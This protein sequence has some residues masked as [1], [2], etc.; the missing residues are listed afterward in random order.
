MKVSH[1][2]VKHVASTLTGLSVQLHQPTHRHGTQSA[3]TAIRRTNGKQKSRQRKLPRKVVRQLAPRAWLPSQAPAPLRSTRRRIL[4][5]HHLETR[6]TGTGGRSK[7]PGQVKLP[8][9]IYRCARCCVL[10]TQSR[11]AKDAC[12][13]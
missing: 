5:R 10:Q 1:K 6:T 12:D 4:R 13:L 8:Q 7:V 2:H 3:L 11:H 9:P